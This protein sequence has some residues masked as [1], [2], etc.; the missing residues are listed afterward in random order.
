MADSSDLDDDLIR[1]LQLFNSRLQS[2]TEQQRAERI[3]TKAERAKTDAANRVRNL[4]N[5]TS[6]TAEARAE[7]EQAYR[8]AVDELAARRDNPLGQADETASPAETNSP[9]GEKNEARDATPEAEVE[10]SDAG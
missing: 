2:A 5:D 1:S 6:A 8:A 4:S 10:Q 9:E 3:V 7:A